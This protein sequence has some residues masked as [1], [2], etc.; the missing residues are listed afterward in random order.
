MQRLLI[1]Y[2]DL[3]TELLQ[4]IHSRYLGYP[5]HNYWYI[6]KPC[7]LFQC[8]VEPGSVRRFVR[9]FEVRQVRGSVFGAKIEVREVRGSVLRFGEPLRTFFSRK[10]LLNIDRILS[11]TMRGKI[12]KFNFSRKSA[13][14]FRNRSIRFFNLGAKKQPKN[15]HAR[16]SQ[17]PPF[18]EY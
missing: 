9:F 16:R 15:L 14:F 18:S 4:N 11:K 10:T 13:P 5:T 2:F 8:W 3:L 6:P 1:F 12:L 17:K 7:N